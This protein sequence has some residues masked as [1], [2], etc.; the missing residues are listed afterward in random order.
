MDTLHD[1]QTMSQ[2][3]ST[4]PLAPDAM[5]NEPP[6]R[7]PVKNRNN[8]S[9]K[10]RWLPYVGAIFLV[11]L[12][13]AGFWPK[14]VPVEAA[15]AVRGAIQSAVN[16][17]G[18][19]RI[20]QRYTVSAPVAGQL[21]RIP[22]KAGAEVKKNETIIAT[23][24]PL[25]PSALDARSRALAEARRGT[26]LA[27]LDRARVAHEFAAS[28][29]KRVQV[30][31]EAKSV[32]IQEFETVQWREL[33]ARK[34]VAAAESALAEAE[35]QLAEFH[36]PAPDATLAPVEIKAPA[37]GQVLRIYEESSRAVA[38]GTPLVEVGDPK[39]LEVI[40]EVLSRDGA[41]I[42]PGAKVEIHQW[43]GPSPIEAVVRLVEPAAFTKISALGVEEQR[44]NVVADLVTPA[45]Q[46]LGLGDAYR[47]EA[48]IITQEIPNA[49]KVPSGALFRR[50]GGWALFAVRNG[51]A[52]LQK[53][54]V[55]LTSG[56][57]TQI[58]SS[59][60]A[61]DSVVLYPGDRIRDGQQIELI[62]LNSAK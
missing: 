55:G 40:V 60:E 18:K 9:K 7:Q 50:E 56:P 43:G 52:Q 10:R 11:G 46:R 47:V 2:P 34:E 53:V 45:H 29:F 22:Y 24:D 19:T 26:A 48:R 16:E 12:I 35:A 36:L 57:E 44:V 61:G 41:A 30:L 13:V 54:E 58:T 33:N 28:E 59:L 17:E 31:L 25:A 4:A 15:K 37:D 23:I 51:R 38:V 3:G 8:R 14:P 21:R 1:R 39:N 6:T 5:K 62:D 49:L 27:N 32:S 42:R 20:S